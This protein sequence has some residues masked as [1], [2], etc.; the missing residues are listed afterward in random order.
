[1][2]EKRVTGI[3]GIFFRS[4][5]PKELVAWY[6]KHLGLNTDD[7]GSTF[8][9]KDNNGLDCST[10]WSP[11]AADTPYFAPS[12][13]QFMQNFRV[14]NL[15]KILLQLKQEGVTVVGEIESYD[16]GKFGWI[17]DIE[18]KKIELWDPIDPIL[19][20]I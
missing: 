6:G 8:T 5:N 13:K 19:N 2:P 9:W 16:Y 14:D 12:E 10:Q 18:G 3:G 17:L 7:Y 1:M 15:E 4:E 11:F 20:K